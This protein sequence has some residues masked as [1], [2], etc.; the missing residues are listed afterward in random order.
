MKTSSR[1]ETTSLQEFWEYTV[2]DTTL[3]T[4]VR[5]SWYPA[6]PFLYR[7]THLD[8][9]LPPSPGICVLGCCLRTLGFLFSCLSLKWT[10]VHSDLRKVRVCANPSYSVE[11]AV[12][13][14]WAPVHALT[15][16]FSKVNYKYTLTRFLSKQELRILQTQTKHH[17]LAFSIRHGI[18]RSFM[19]QVSEWFQIEDKIQI[20]WSKALADRHATH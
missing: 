6:V 17:C 13:P 18:L 9:L 14:S 19:C 16:I 15:S 1:E 4:E 2:A 20:K 12:V 10:G 7:Q 11:S 3:N 5:R 8:L